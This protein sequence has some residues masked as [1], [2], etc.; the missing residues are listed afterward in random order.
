MEGNVFMSQELQG[1]VKESVTHLG[2]NTVIV[3]KHDST[4]KFVGGYH[5]F[6][7][8]PRLL[9][10]I[11]RL[12]DDFPPWLCESVGEKVKIG[13]V[14]RNAKISRLV[15]LSQISIDCED[16]AWTLAGEILIEGK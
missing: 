7:L 2:A 3:Q 15:Q 5:H 13:I 12:D 9:K 16:E 1:R 14:L 11:G 8:S 10:V 4:L 6:F